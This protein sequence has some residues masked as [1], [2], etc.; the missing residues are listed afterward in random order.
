MPKIQ[1]KCDTIHFRCESEFK[2]QIQDYVDAYNER[3]G[4]IQKT[5]VTEVIE[6]A[7]REYLRRYSDRMPI[8]ERGQ[9]TY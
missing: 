4:H 8:I 6:E 7:I 1:I 5:N 9:K 2:R 3:Y